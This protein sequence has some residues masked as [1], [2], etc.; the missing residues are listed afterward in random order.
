MKK[1]RFE[2]EEYWASTSHKDY[3]KNLSS[4]LGRHLPPPD[5][6]KFHKRIKSDIEKIRSS[7]AQPDRLPSQEAIDCA[8]KA[9]REFDLTLF[10]SPANVD[11]LVSTL[12]DVTTALINTLR[13]LVSTPPFDDKKKKHAE[14]ISRGF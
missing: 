8:V 5:L 14:K 6:A 4:Y 3:Q 1:N 13:A 12:G 9:L 11:P 7:L 2:P 10:G